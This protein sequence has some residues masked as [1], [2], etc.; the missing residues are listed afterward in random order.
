MLQKKL[1]THSK[2]ANK[3]QY[4]QIQAYIMTNMYPGIYDKALDE[5]KKI[6]NIEKISV[7]TGDYDIVVKVNVKN[8]GQLHKLTSQ[9][10]KVEGVE[11]TNTQVIEKEFKTF[12]KRSS[13]F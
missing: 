12:L 8:L 9:L 5:I 2:T 10:H 4:G 13:W 3:K 6:S 1:L 7:V 11:K